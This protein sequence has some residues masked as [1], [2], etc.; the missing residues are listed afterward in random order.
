[1]FLHVSRYSSLD[2]SMAQKALCPE[3]FSSSQ[4]GAVFCCQKNEFC[5]DI[6]CFSY[7]IMKKKYA[8][9][10]LVIARP[11]TAIVTI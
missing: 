7:F 4:I 10:F 3:F 9:H 11:A 8:S 5:D 6:G 1:M 2:E